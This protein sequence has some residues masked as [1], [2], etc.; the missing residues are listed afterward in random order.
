VWASTGGDSASLGL[1]GVL[2]GDVP[3][4]GSA[5]RCVLL[6]DIY[7]LTVTGPGGQDSAQLTIAL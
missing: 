3:P 6:G 1:L 2:G 5:T 4:S 7:L